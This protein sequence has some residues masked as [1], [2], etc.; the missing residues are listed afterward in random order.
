M[1][2]PFET[3]FKSRAGATSLEFALVSLPFLGLLLGAISVAFNLYLQFALD[4]ALQQAVRQVQLG[5]V[6]ASL[7]AGDFV[8]TVFCPV[9]VTFAPCTGVAA[10]VQPVSDYSGGPVVASPAAL[11]AFCVGQPG[12]LMYSRITYQAP[13]LGSIY[14]TLVNPSLPGTSGNLI[15]SAAAFANENPSGSPAAKAAGC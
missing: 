13:V 1:R 9:F 10:S 12:Q 15:V 7:S 3:L 2:L 5:H 11:S 8:G 4:Y 14:T 6:P